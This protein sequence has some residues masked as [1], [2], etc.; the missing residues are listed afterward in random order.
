MNPCE[1]ILPFQMEAGDGVLI[2]KALRAYRPTAEEEGT[3]N[4]FIEQFAKI[5]EANLT[6][7]ARS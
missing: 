7:E 2:A 5:D 6:G 3:V 4:F 1:T